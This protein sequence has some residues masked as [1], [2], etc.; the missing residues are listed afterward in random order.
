MSTGGNSGTPAPISFERDIKPLFREN[1]IAC[2]SSM[3]VLLD[4]YAFM[5]NPDNAKNVLDHLTGDTQPQ[6]PLGGPFW[7]DAQIALFKSWINETPPFQ[8]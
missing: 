8:P 6:M 4:D 5:S 7:S 2:M 3:G 1:D